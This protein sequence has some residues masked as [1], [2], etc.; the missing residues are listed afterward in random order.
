MITNYDKLF[1]FFINRLPWKNPDLLKIWLETIPLKN[2]KPGIYTKICS[3]HFTD[4]CYTT[5]FTGGKVRLKK[6]AV[7]TILQ[8]SPN[9]D[10]KPKKGTVIIF[11]IIVDMQNSV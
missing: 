3:D 5:T 4:D 7:P 8:F 1:L 9:Q 6:D 10:L 11:S 2:A